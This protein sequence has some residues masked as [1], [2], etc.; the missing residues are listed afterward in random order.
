MKDTVIDF[1]FSIFIVIASMHKHNWFLCIDFVV[2]DLTKHN[3]STSLS[4]RFSCRFCEWRLISSF[5]VYM[6]L[7]LSLAFMH[8]LGYQVEQERW[9]QTSLPLAQ[10]RG[11][12][13]LC[14][15]ESALSRLPAG[16]APWLAFPQVLCRLCT[17]FPTS[18]ALWWATGVL[19]L[20]N[21]PW[22]VQ[23]PQRKSSMRILVVKDR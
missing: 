20:L 10:S 22:Q 1:Q 23:H 4:C 15:I 19:C 9:G 11:S 6:P 13:G 18:L 16:F 17:W 3:Y 2:C 12:V 8:W 21:R 7:F 14:L 5:P